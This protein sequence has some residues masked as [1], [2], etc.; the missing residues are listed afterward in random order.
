MI[1]YIKGALIKC[2]FNVLLLDMSSFNCADSLTILRKLAFLAFQCN[3]SL[4]G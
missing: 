1:Y 3:H 2:T 4:F